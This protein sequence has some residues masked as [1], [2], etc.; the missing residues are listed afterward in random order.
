MYL[1]MENNDAIHV[2]KMRTQNEE[3]NRYASIPSLVTYGNSIC[4][5]VRLTVCH[6]PFI[7][8][9]IFFFFFSIKSYF[10]VFINCI[11]LILYSLNS[12]RYSGFR[13]L[14][15]CALC[16]VQCVSLAFIHICSTMHILTNHV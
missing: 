3:K 16:M 5:F 6:L 10:L 4:L 7:S 13:T 11:L 15:V 1:Y 8:K 9:W 12:N 14:V 2:S